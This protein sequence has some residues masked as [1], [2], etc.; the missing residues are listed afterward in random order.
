MIRGKGITCGL[1][2]VSPSLSSTQGP[3]QKPRE[4]RIQVPLVDLGT[5]GMGYIRTW[6]SV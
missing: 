4:G 6:D 1:S 5:M 2:F 3:S